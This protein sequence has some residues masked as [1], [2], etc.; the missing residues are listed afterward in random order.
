MNGLWFKDGFFNYLYTEEESF[1]EEII[2]EVLEELID[3]AYV[4]FSGS[5]K[6]VKDYMY[7]SQTIHWVNPCK[8]MILE[9]PKFNKEDIINEVDSLTLDD[10][11]FVNNHYEYRS[12][13]SL[14]KICDAIK[15]RP[16][17]C[18]RIDGKPVS[19][20]ALNG[21]DSIGYMY[22]LKEH[23]N[24]GYAYEVTKDISLK[25]IESG[26]VPFVQIHHGNEKSLNLA[27][28][29][30]FE[31]YDDVYWFGI[32]NPNGEDLKGDLR[33]YKDL[34]SYEATHIST[35]LNMLLDFTPLEVEVEDM[36][37]HVRVSFKGKTF[38][39][40]YIYED[41]M[42]FLDLI[43]SVSNELLRSILIKFLSSED[44]VCLLSLSEKFDPTGFR[45][46]NKL[47]N[48]R[49]SS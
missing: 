28:K 10:A 43:D 48:H 22:T 37:D 4:E 46:L 9:K 33:K 44:Y 27:L 3:S 15:N 45:K 1:L 29:V 7:I 14:D 47:S 40:K 32:L 11:E 8:L 26:R 5:N 16:T 34:Y 36:K 42:Y 30:G 6:F 39:I 17:S 12:D 24:K 18:V 25:V 41:E 31:E 38:R 19:Y 20:A 2:E 21:D 35:K 49:I 13:Y 23:R